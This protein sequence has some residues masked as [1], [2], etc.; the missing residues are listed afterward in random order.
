MNEVLDLMKRHRSRRRFSAG[1]LPRSVLHE[2]VDAARHASTSSLLQTY[3][4]I[5][6][7][8][9]ER[10]RVV[11]ELCSEQ[12]MILEAPCFLAICVDLHRIEAACEVAG[13]KAGLADL[14]TLVLGCAD[15]SLLGQNL[16]LALESQGYGGCF[17]G[18]ARNHPVELARVLQLPPRVF[19]VFGMV[20]GVPVDEPLPR[21]RMPLEAIL[22][23]EVYDDA[24]TSQGLATMD[25]RQRD[26]ARRTNTE[27]GGHAGRLVNTDRGWCARVR[28]RMDA[29]RPPAPRD[30]LRSQL[31]T[32]GFCLDPDGPD[33]VPA[34]TDEAG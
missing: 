24:R 13:G 31:E 25:E 17:V 15:A 23:D 22:H 9:E 18:A 16:M 2:C 5:V 19:V 26:W 21:P 20:A 29:E 14:E 10:K 1:D 8:D 34:D 7:R 6:V 30:R 27:K 3:S 33:Q 32:L 28:H 4:V 12:E 11:Y